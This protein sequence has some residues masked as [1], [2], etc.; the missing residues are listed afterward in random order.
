MVDADC[1]AGH[2]CELRICVPGC[3]TAAACDA[4]EVC[5]PHGRCAAE[6]MI[7]APRPIGGIPTL[8]ERTTVLAP[9]ETHATTIL[10]NDGPSVLVYRLAAASPALVVDGELAELAPG[11]EVLLVADVDL[12]AL[13]PADRVLP[14]QVITSGGAILWSLE[15]EAMP[16]SGSF[17]G[18][19]S[20][21]VDGHSLG[22]SA[23]AIDLDFRADGTIAGRV[24]NHASLLWPQ[25]LA[26]TGT[27]A[28]DGNFTIELRD[29]LPAEDWRHSPISRDLGRVLTL[30][31]TRDGEMLTGTATMTLTGMRAAVVQTA[32]AFTLRRHGPLEGLVLPADFVPDD[33]LAP[34]W[35]APPG[36][37]VAACDGLGADYGTDDTLVE[38]EPACDACAA[39]NCSADD[40]MDCGAAIHEAAYNLPEVLA[41][42]QGDDVQPPEGPWTWD[43][44]TAS[45]PTYLGG[46]ACLDIVAQRCAGSLIRRG[47]AEI[48]GPWGERYEPSQRT[49]PPTRPTPRP[50]CRSRPRWTQRSPT[51][52]RSV[53]RPPTP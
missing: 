8:D 44:C 48:V 28:P 41:A 40:M 50:C 17:R 12:A 18:A 45:S 35:L 23:L 53:S 38:P 19:V 27:W 6:G 51:R 46:V 43:V 20:F 33:A 32:A 3:D 24:D 2:F 10:R 21:E 5:D 7:A 16:S 49:S 25:P 39:G 30:T 42:L 29:L 22:Q 13:G 4:G 36:L 9:K 26:L 31:G 1:D 15:F 34:L 52:T 11:D 37:D 47:S 14:V